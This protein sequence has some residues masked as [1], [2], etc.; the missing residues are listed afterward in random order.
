VVQTPTDGVSGSGTDG[1]K[2]DKNDES[3][4]ADMK[5]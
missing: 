1:E 2:G 4:G 5:A 3:W